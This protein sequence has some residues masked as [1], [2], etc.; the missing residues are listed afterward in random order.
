MSYHNVMKKR[1]LL[2][3]L[4]VFSIAAQSLAE[5]W[6]KRLPDS[7]LPSE[8]S[9]PGAHDAATGS[10]WGEGWDDM[11]D[12]FART[13][14]LSL[15]QLWA[16]GIRAFDLRPCVYED[17]MNVNHGMV[18][19]AVH[20]ESALRLLC[21][22][23]RA[24]PSEFVVVHLL[25]ESDGDQVEGTYNQRIQQLLGQEEWQDF[26]I[27]FRTD[28][29]VGDLRG[30]MLIFSRDKYAT[31]PVTG[32]FFENWTGDINWSKQLAVRITGQK[33]VTARACVQD[34][35][36]THGQ[37]GVEKK[38]QAIV[39]MLD[40]TT[41]YKTTSASTVRW[42]FNF[43]S[44]YSLVQSIFGF[45]VSTSDGYRDNAT[46]THAAI[47]GYL[48]EKPAGPTGVIL[49]DFA[50]VDQSGDYQVRGQELVDA[51][52]AN[53]F[54]YI[55]ENTTA[56]TPPAADRRQ[57][58]ASQRQTFLSDGRRS[59]SSNGRRLCVQKGRKIVT[60]Q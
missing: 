18:A 17:Y 44:A 20:F 30:K 21:D 35:S 26:L 28:L 54:R 50:G 11:G 37:G 58:A 12:A 45:E 29:T 16:A 55:E 23:L 19:T 13:Q 6:M 25:H 53:N 31:Y 2:S 48:K 3:A 51:I 57:T 39:R 27:D 33:G 5:N 9:I 1:I 24:N 4:A 15:G 10:G 49:M 40:A 38:V 14:E 34:Y 52:I 41:K 32:G 60:R 8:L 22:S 47:I 36:D 46:H 59:P 42:A 7:S 56:V 43:A